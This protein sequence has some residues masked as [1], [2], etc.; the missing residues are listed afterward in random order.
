M[1]VRRCVQPMAACK[2]DCYNRQAQKTML[3]LRRQE[4][5]VAN[6]VAREFPELAVCQMRESPDVDLV[7]VDGYHVGLEIV[8]AVDEQS[9]S[10]RELI[11]GVCRSVQRHFEHNRVSGA[12]TLYFDLAEVSVAT[13]RQQWKKRLPAKLSEFLAMN[14]E[15]KF[16]MLELKRQGIE[17]LARVERRVSTGTQVAMGWSS[18]VARFENTL[19]AIALAAKHELLPKYRLKNPEFREYWLA[20]VGF[21]PGT[22][23]DGGFSVLL[24]RQYASTYDRVLL[25]EHNEWGRFVA[26]RDVTPR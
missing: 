20:I 25:I 21:G 4:E 26:A 7:H 24:S 15:P 2:T 1:D 13:G 9:L 10:M 17:R 6:L 23:E 3:S 19:V 16:E 5:E 11:R 8:R 18:S 14:N 22:V 12:F